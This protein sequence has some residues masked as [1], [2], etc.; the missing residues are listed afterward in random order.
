MFLD[1]LMQTDVVSTLMQASWETLLLYGALFFLCWWFLRRMAAEDQADHEAMCP[2]PPEVEAEAQ[3]TALAWHA[4]CAAERARL[5]EIA[6]S[7]DYDA[8]LAPIRAQIAAQN[9]R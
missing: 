3:R 2:P 6:G 9:Q 4:H 1:A 5:D 8:Y 7:R